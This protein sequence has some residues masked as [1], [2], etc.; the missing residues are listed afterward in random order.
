MVRKDDG[1]LDRELLAAAQAGD[2]DAFRRLVELHRADIHSL[3]YRMLGRLHDAEDA[4]QDTM[5]RAWRALDGF[6]D[7]SQLSTWLHRIATNVCLDAL[8]RSARRRMLPADL[9]H[10]VSV[11]DVEWVGPYPDAV[12]GVPDGFADPSARFDRRESL[13]LAFI[14]ALQLLPARQ[15]AALILC[16]VLG[17]RP[18]EV[19]LML[20][21]TTA[22]INS[23]LQRARARLASARPNV[24]QRSAA[25]AMGPAHLGRIVERFASALEEGD[26]ETLTQLLAADVVFEMPPH[27]ECT[28]GRAAVARS[29]LVPA[30]RPTH[31]RTV[32]TQ[33]NGQPAVA[34]YRIPPAVP[35]GRPSPIAVDV[36]GFADG[37]I[38][39][40]T[41]FRDADELAA[42]TV[43]DDVFGHGPPVDNVYGA[44]CSGSLAELTATALS[45]WYT[46]GNDDR[47]RGDS[48]DTDQRSAGGQQEERHGSRRL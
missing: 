23:A 14:T 41:A 13:G 3:C 5:L 31:L 16:E 48:S 45:E 42:L 19:A 39:R 22:A 1:R 17:F 20:D 34:V 4:Y 2:E 12:I 33:I 8:K 37:L 9:R 47:S 40:L 24:S 32:I 26:T 11:D 29:W 15:R 30:R 38:S 44:T 21:T 6:D 46:V 25:R 28:R 10:S 7:R 18:G 35:S 43:A 36:L 27:P